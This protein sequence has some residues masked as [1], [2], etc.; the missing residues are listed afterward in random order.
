MRHLSLA[1]LMLVVLGGCAVQTEGDMLEEEALGT[2]EDE[3]V[4]GNIPMPRANLVAVT[5]DGTVVPAPGLPYCSV[6]GTDLVIRVKNTGL[7]GAGP[8]YTLIR[9]TDPTKFLLVATPGLAVG[10]TAEI[11]IDP[12]A[13]LVGTGGAPFWISVD[14]ANQITELGEANTFSG[15]CVR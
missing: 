2:A 12:Q 10:E 13:V 9:G 7:L 5:P 14:A 8:S 15:Y 3:L 1:A 6:D 11:A 4:V